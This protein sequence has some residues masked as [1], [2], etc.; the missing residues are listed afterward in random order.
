MNAF[1]NNLKKAVCGLALL[2]FAAT[3]AAA[4][5]LYHVVLDVT[6]LAG[7]G[8]L[9]LQFNPGQ[10][11]AALAFANLN[12]FA[13]QTTAGA[14]AQVAGSVSGVFGGNNLLFTNNT[15]YNDL[16][17]G[18]QLGQRISFDVHFSGPFL[19]SSNNV[20]TSFGLA[21]YANDQ[22]TV[23]GHGDAI[24]GNLLQFDLTPSQ[25]GTVT[26]TVFDGGLITVSAVPEPSEYAMMLA[27]LA[28]LGV[29]ARRRKAA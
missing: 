25:P 9:D 26:T 6:G 4:D 17:T 29:I 5:N 24:S 13:G 27:G 10:D 28:A 1:I 19:T 12:H 18:V 8:W 2:G 14:T 23:L 7:N 15:A 22:A 20:G 21:L 11:G 16:F 3:A